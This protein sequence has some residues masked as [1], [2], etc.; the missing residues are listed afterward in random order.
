MCT[1]KKLSTILTGCLQVIKGKRT[2]YCN[3]IFNNSGINQMW[4]LKN[5][6]DLLEKCDQPLFAKAKCI[7]T[8]DFSTLYTSIPHRQLKKQLFNLIRDTMSITRFSILNYSGRRCFLSNEAFDGYMSFS[9]EDLCELLGFLIDNI[10]VSFGNT[11]MRQVIG[12]PM[13]TDC[14]PLL[15]DLFLH[16]YEAAFIQKLMKNK[17]TFHIAK[18]FNKTDRYFDDLIS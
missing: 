15:A 1:T 2:A 4:I 13:G 11:I 5:S 9:C 3:A 14:A 7:S 6:K 10:Y 8:W 16:S 18:S 12:I 17:S